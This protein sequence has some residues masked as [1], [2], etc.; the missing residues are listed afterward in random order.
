ML[1]NVAPDS[2]ARALASMVFPH[3]GGPKSKTPFGAP[4]REDDEVNRFGYK[5]GYITD[6]RRDAIIGSNPPMSVYMIY[7]KLL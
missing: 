2:L 7:D 4:N 5:R 6:S 1:M 3:P